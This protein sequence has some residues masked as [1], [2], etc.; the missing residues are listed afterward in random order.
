MRNATVY[1]GCSRAKN[2]FPNLLGYRL[3]CYGEF[4][5]TRVVLRETLAS[6]NIGTDR[7][8]PAHPLRLRSAAQHTGISKHQPLFSLSPSSPF[9][10]QTTKRFCSLLLMK[11]SWMLPCLTFCFLLFFNLEQPSCSSSPEKNITI[12][13]TRSFLNFT[14]IG[15]S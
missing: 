4:L 5:R 15:N 2:G 7:K 8:R 6:S 12:S 9:L 3:V 13:S 1:Q 14:Y 10:V 11:H